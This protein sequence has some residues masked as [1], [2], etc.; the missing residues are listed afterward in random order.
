MI[1]FT[2]REVTKRAWRLCALPKRFLWATFAAISKSFPLHC[3]HARLVLQIHLS[4]IVL[5]ETDL[6]ILFET[7]IFSI[8]RR[9]MCS[10]DSITHSQVTWSYTPFASRP[11]L[12][13]LRAARGIESILDNSA[14]LCSNLYVQLPRRATLAG[15][16]SATRYAHSVS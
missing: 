5:L 16:P 12:L 6:S 8:R 13:S 1:L 9:R 15:S 7:R 4:K 14:W 3:F 10:P 11:E 2:L